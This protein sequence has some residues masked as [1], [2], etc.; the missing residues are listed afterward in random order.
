MLK[1]FKNWL[2]Q[3]EPPIQL[4]QQRKLSERVT[5][6]QTEF[7]LTSTSDCYTLKI[8]TRQ[9]ISDLIKI[10]K[11]SYDGKAPWSKIAFEHEMSVNQN[12][13][14]LIIKNAAQ[15]AVGF[16]G[17]WFVEGEAHI[18]NVAVQPIYQRRGIGRLLI[19]ELKKIAI[20]E[21]QTKMSLEVRKSNKNAQSLYH[22]LG[23]SDGKIKQSYYSDDHEDALEM[24]LSLNE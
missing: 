10:E 4:N 15:E 18:T 14:Y 16:I 22:Q 9:D 5:L 21:K 1:K 3:N 8:G 11:L 19:T 13:I 12:S 6:V 24:G 23:F 2:L 17:A 20:S 7:R